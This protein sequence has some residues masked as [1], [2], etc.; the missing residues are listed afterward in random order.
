MASAV[1]PSAAQY[2]ALGQEHAY[3]V[4]AAM[5]TLVHQAL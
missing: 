1:A 5:P 4:P 2:I 3:V